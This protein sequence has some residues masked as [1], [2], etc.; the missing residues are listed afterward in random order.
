MWC[1]A[2]HSDGRQERTL[3]PRQQAEGRKLVTVDSSLV[4]ASSH[5]PRRGG[6]GG[7][8]PFAKPQ[9]TTG[10]EGAE[11]HRQGQ[12]PVLRFT[13][14]KDASRV[15]APAP[16]F[17]SRFMVLFTYFRE[18]PRAFRWLY[19]DPSSNTYCFLESEKTATC[20][21]KRT[22]VSTQKVA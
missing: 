2:R 17:P 10:R 16:A 9:E 4:M 5:R 6:H 15:V 18:A 22:V 12:H 1:E 8:G 14:C 21:G 20:T 11:R 3:T 7:A 13:S 19:K